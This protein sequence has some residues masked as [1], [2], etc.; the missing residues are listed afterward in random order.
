MKA[1]FVLILRTQVTRGRVAALGA[2]GLLGIVLGVAVGQGNTFDKADSAYDLIGSYGLNLLVPLTALVFAA[3][4]L[5]DPTEDGTLVYLWHRPVSRTSIA[6]A[7][8]AAALCI[9]LPF[10][11]LPTV[12]SALATGTG[13]GVVAG[14]AASSLLATAAYS[15]LFLLLGLLVRRALTWGLTYVLIWEGFVARSGTGPA[16]LS[17]LVYAQSV[18]ADLADHEPPRLAASTPVAL[19][20]PLTLAALAIGL[21]IWSLRRLDVK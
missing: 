12:L 21:T 16:R 11:V 5:G 18:L 17:I 3:A 1:I 10:A 7:A 14:A 13:S 20:V 2:V 8:W 6:L 15:G 4:A 19:L 9:A